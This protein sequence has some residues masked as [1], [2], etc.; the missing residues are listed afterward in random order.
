VAYRF[1]VITQRGERSG[2]GVECADP[3]SPQ[4]TALGI[5][6]YAVGVV[7]EPAPSDH[8]GEPRGA[9]G[10]MWS[11]RRECRLGNVH[12]ADGLGE[13]DPVGIREPEPVATIVSPDGLGHSLAKR[14]KSGSR[15]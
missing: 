5:D 9:R 11:A 12:R 4:T 6:P 8:L 10:V 14:P 13:V 15:A 1:I 7:E 3:H 2:E